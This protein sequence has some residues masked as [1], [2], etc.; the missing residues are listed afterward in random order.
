MQFV[1]MNCVFIFRC[2]LYYSDFQVERDIQ[3][4]ADT[5]A[6]AYAKLTQNICELYSEINDAGEEEY[7]AG[8]IICSEKKQG[9]N[10]EYFEEKGDLQIETN[11]E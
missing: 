11:F 6:G 2:E 8:F 1:E 3:I 10:L 4:I 5:V 9:L 7:P